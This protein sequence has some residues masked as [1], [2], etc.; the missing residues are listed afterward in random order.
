LRCR[1]LRGTMKFRETKPV[2]FINYIKG[3]SPDDEHP[4]IAY[5]LP[6]EGF[7]WATPYSANEQFE[8][9]RHFKLDSKLK[10]L[11]TQALIDLREIH[12]EQA[13]KKIQA[14]ALKGER[15]NEDEA[16][17]KLHISIND[18]LE[19]DDATIKK[20]MDLLVERAAQTNNLLYRF[21]LVSPDT[22][23]GVN[24]ARFADHDQFTVYFDKYSS[25]AEV[26]QLCNDIKM[27]LDENGM[28]NTKGLGPKDLLA[29]NTF[30]SARYDN[31]KLTQ[32]YNLFHFYDLELEKF[33]K[34]YK[35]RENE[36]KEVP[37]CVFEVVFNN[38]LIDPNIAELKSEGLAADASKRVQLQ[39]DAIIKNPK[40]YVA[41]PEELIEVSTTV[42][43][44]VNLD[45]SREIK[46]LSAMS[47]DDKINLLSTKLL[48]KTNIQ[49]E[50]K[51]INHSMQFFKNYPPSYQKLWDDA[52]G[53][54]LDKAKA[55]F[56]DY[57][58][59]TRLLKLHW[60]RHYCTKVEKLLKQDIKS[61][62]EFIQKLEQIKIEAGESFNQHGSFSKRL[63]FLK[64]QT[65]FEQSIRILIS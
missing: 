8:L 52:H 63:E 36:L 41:H 4:N 12:A 2:D 34:R 18:I 3:L 21:K 48:L 16:S 6:W 31:N 1:L 50:N 25:I 29:M 11:Y 59:W 55:L 23:T 32:E 44:P 30:V 15:Y 5:K 7:I 40:H 10:G 61:T 37:L 26:V 42:E 14:N 64:Q 22:I 53:N 24:L 19:Q 49:Q 38:I 45:I 33:F 35:G 47:E 65:K 51:K 20:V 17:F 60:N 43:N 56:A 28:K 13:E 39:L 57:S 27:V 9:K 46:K 62:A 58:S 54:S